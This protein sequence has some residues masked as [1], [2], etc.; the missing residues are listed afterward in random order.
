M[1]SLLGK[2]LPLVQITQFSTS[3][4]CK[5]C[6]CLLA[7]AEGRA[8]TLVDV[9]LGLRLMAAPRTSSPDDPAD[10]SLPPLEPI[11]I[12]LPNPFLVNSR[13]LYRITLTNFE[14]HHLVLL[15]GR[16]QECGCLSLY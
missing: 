6:L 4:R 12:P 8:V 2:S 10:S 5:P 7:G 3:G 1:D 15:G 9:T 13:A 11:S 16:A 14:T